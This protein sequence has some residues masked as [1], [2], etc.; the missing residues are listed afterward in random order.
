M[1]APKSAPVLSAGLDWR[2]KAMHSKSGLLKGGRTYGFSDLRCDMARF[3]AYCCGSLHIDIQYRRVE[4]A[5]SVAE[6]KGSYLDLSS[7]SKEKALMKIIATKNLAAAFVVFACL[8]SAPIASASFK[9]RIDNLSNP[10]GATTWGSPANTVRVRIKY[11]AY[12]TLWT[13]D[14]PAVN[15]LREDHDIIADYT[16]ADVQY[17]YVE[18]TTDDMFGLDQVEVFNSSNTLLKTYGADNQNA[19]CL[20]TDPADA[21][22]A[23]CGNTEANTSV[24]FYP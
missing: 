23:E 15:L 11:K 16:W 18:N 14:I 6:N 12:S 1:F 13:Y 24:T 22:S 9:I 4:Y 21:Y 17:F 2:H 5:V 20:S 3:R 7:I 10:A 19:W 8:A